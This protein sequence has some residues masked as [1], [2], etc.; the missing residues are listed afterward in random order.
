MKKII[1]LNLLFNTVHSDSGNSG[2]ESPQSFPDNSK[3][4]IESGFGIK[5]GQSYVRELKV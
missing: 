4:Y 1:I 5:T 2:E 3:I